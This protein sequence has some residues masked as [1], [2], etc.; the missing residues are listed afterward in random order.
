MIEQRQHIRQRVRWRVAIRQDTKPPLFGE[1][2]DISIAGTSILADTNIVSGV[3][4]TLYLQI[5]PQKAGNP[6]QVVEVSARLQYT[7]FSPGHDRWRM[8]LQF[9]DMKPEA[10][11]ILEQALRQLN[12]S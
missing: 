8:G 1:T 11:R 5:P 9:L 4:V 12:S 2:L 10:G 6:V 3:T 7:S